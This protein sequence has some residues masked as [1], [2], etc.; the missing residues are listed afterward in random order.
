MKILSIVFALLLISACSTLSQMSVFTLSEAELEHALDAQVV[1]LQKKASVAGIPVLLNVDDL[2][3]TIG[4]EGQDIVHLATKARATVSAFGFRYPLK[5][6]IALAGTPY[7]DNQEKAIYVRS[8][9]LIDSTIDAGGFRGNVAPLS[10]EF[11]QLINGYL[12]ANPVY[13]LDSTN[14]AVSLLSHMPLKLSVEEGQL[15]LRPTS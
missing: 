9:S 1:K 11:M 2:T 4:P 13:R 5:L 14:K 8:L 15:A 3:V 7:Y 10:G 6:R 12:A